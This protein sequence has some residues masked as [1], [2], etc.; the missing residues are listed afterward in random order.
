[1]GI[2]KGRETKPVV[3]EVFNFII[4]KV[5]RDDNDLYCPEAIFKNSV[6]KIPNYPKNI[7]YADM[8]GGTDLA[9]K[10]RLLAKWKY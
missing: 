6:N 10:E 4:S 5:V 1:M 9:L 2:I 3:R 7:P 8:K